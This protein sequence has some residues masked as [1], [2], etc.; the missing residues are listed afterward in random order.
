MW[1]KAQEDE[2]TQQKEVNIQ[3]ISSPVV[4]SKD[5]DVYQEYSEGLN[6]VETVSHVS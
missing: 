4:R 3:N 1:R 2:T 6:I 5:T